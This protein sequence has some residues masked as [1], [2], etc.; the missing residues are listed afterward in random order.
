MAKFVVVPSK[1]IEGLLSRLGDHRLAK[2]FR[3]NED[4]YR[5]TLIKAGGR[6]QREGLKSHSAEPGRMKRNLRDKVAMPMTLYENMLKETK[7]TGPKTERYT[8]PDSPRINPSVRRSRDEER[9][10]Q[11]RSSERRMARSGLKIGA[12]ARD[13]WGK[14]QPIRDSTGFTHGMRE[15]EDRPNRSTRLGPRKDAAPVD[16]YYL[17]EHQERGLLP[18]KRSK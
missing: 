7:K 17:T 3:S 1:I 10:A 9:A 15:L 12:P 16:L 6:L 4:R 5:T 14:R 13:G 18:K 11:Q 2:Y 8:L